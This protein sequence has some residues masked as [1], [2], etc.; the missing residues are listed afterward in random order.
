M[1]HKPGIYSA[2]SYFSGCNICF[3]I[4]RQKLPALYRHNNFFQTVSPKLFKQLH[5]LLP[6]EHKCKHSCPATHT[7]H[8]QNTSEIERMMKRLRKDQSS[9]IISAINMLGHLP[10]AYF[11]PI[12]L[13]LMSTVLCVLGS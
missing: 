11:S 7:K 4:D 13:V 3:T 6:H 8:W 12:W 2:Q 5:I 9:H 1:F 10:T